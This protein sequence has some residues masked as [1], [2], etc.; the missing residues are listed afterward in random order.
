MLTITSAGG[1]REKLAGGFSIKK[2]HH[3][4]LSEFIILPGFL[5]CT[6]TMIT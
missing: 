4:T 3:L 6:D 5:F 1:G 2:K